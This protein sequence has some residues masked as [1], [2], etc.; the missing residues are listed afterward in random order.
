V[1]SGARS[2]RRERPAPGAAPRDSGYLVY[3]IPGLVLFAL[4]I[5]LPFAMNLWFSLTNWQGV[6]S[7]EWTGLDNYRRLL[8]DETFWAS[9]RH[10]AALIVAMAIVPTALGLLIAA[11]LFDYI[12][13]KFGTGTVAALRACFYLPQVLPIAVAGV[14]WGWI[15]NPTSGALNASLEKVGLGS[16]AQDWLGDPSLALFTVMVIMVWVQLGFPVVIFMAGLQRVDPALYEA[17][18]LDGASWMKRF[19][20]ITVPQ[21][22]P[23]VYV[24]LLWTTI[25]A[26]KVFGPI[27][28]L[29]RGGP[30]GATN[31]PA[32]Y[33]YQNFFER[34]QVGYGA[35]IAT[36][37]TLL[38]VA[39][40]VVFLR[41]Q[42]PAEEVS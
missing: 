24:V 32:Y 10:N 33:S 7:P 27:Y 14:V 28:V 15:L 18:E 2:R 16:L 26:L 21:I 25:A 40:S 38:I 1:N 6:G 12:A 19:R 37:L 36:V 39:L 9:F 8:Q 34:T 30:G 11:A 20:H 42:R 22:K 29:T 41:I 17:A 31:V 23:E 3:L 5:A 13:K 4:V 35:A